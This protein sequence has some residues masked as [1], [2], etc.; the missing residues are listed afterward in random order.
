MNSRAGLI[1]G[2]VL[3]GVVVAAALLQLGDGD[4]PSAEEPVATGPWL[5]R[6]RTFVDDPKRSEEVVSETTKAIRSTLMRGIQ[7][8]DKGLIASGLA[9]D[10]EGE[11]FDP[12]RG[13]TVEDAS[14]E[15]RAL[16]MKGA[17]PVDGSTFVDAIHGRFSHLAAIE[18]VSWRAFTALLSADEASQYVEA[19][20]HVAGTV[21]KGREEW[22]AIARAE[23]RRGTGVHAG[24][25][26]PWK[27]HR[28]DFS[29]VELIRSPLPPFVDVTDVVGF[30]FNPSE[31]NRALL[32]KMIDMRK[33]FNSGGLSA[34]DFNRD[35][36]WD[37]LATRADR[38]TILFLNDGQG[39]FTQTTLPSISTPS[40]AD[41]H[42]LFVDLDNDGNDELVSTKVITDS[43]PKGR[44][45]LYSFAGKRMKLHPR[46][47]EF[48]KPPVVREMN[49]EAVTVCD[50]DG[51]QQLDLLFLGYNQALSGTDF[52]LVDA[53]DGLKNLL[54]MNK[55]N[56]RFEEASV[57]RGIVGTRYS[58]VA[59]CFDFDRDGDPDIFIGNDFGR[60]RYFDNRGGGF[61]AED[62]THPFHLGAGY[63]MG[64][65]M[66]DFDN[67]GEYAVSIANMYSHAGN[68]IV[69]MAPALDDDQRS[70]LSAI[71]GGNTL[72]ERQGA[73]WVERGEAR[74]L[75][76][77][78]WAWGNQ[79]FDF[80]N[81]TDK[82]Q[83]VVNGYTTHS[84]PDAP[85]F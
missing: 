18:R 36:F 5:E 15:I 52:N 20:F 71:A 51:D 78:D 37:V 48:D 83:L 73:Q 55:G 67:T 59:A 58:Y 53:R 14:M 84:D 77:A 22:H 26:P 42:Y 12:T 33:T 28:L 31:Q 68:R 63:S 61:F 2:L 70:M 66:S 47:L 32:S 43:G 44:L 50:V 38:E 9:R 30:N 8:R 54:F 10:F 72:Y 65:S 23:V 1:A 3:I 46:A 25:E 17:T 56:L 45:A 41:R 4:R 69:P 39:G 19:H 62:T 75:Q 60:N 81:D 16:D 40:D 80:D 11:L 27:L 35:G 24:G 76:F 82:D 29:D 57:E 21:A 34:V 64:F 13:R 49:F 79:F 6:P 7:E 85:D 74:G